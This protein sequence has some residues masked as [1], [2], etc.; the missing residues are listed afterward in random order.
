MPN[1]NKQNELIK[2]YLLLGNSYLERKKYKKALESFN[3]V[4]ELDSNNKEAY[5]NKGY[6]YIALKKYEKALESFNKVIEL[7][8]NNK[9]SYN[10]KGCVKIYLK[11][12]KEALENFNKVIELDPRYVDSYY[13][14]G[15]LYFT[16]FKEYEE[17]LPDFNKVIILKPDYKEAYNSRGILYTKLEKYKEALQDYNKGIELAPDCEVFYFNRGSLYIELKR[18]EKALKDYNKVIEIN[19]N[20]KEAYYNRGYLYIALEKYKEALENFNKAIE[21]NKGYKRAYNSRGILYNILADNEITI[22]EKL[23]YYINA[24]NDFNSAKGENAKINKK[25]TE[26]KLIMNKNDY[27]EKEIKTLKNSKID[28]EK[29]DYNIIFEELSKNKNLA[30]E[31]SYY[32][33]KILINEL[34]EVLKK[35]QNDLNIF[36]NLKKM[37]CFYSAEILGEISNLIDKYPAYR[38]NLIRTIQT[39]F[40]ENLERNYSLFNKKEKNLDI[41]FVF[42]YKKINKRTLEAIIKKG[43]HKSKAEYFNDVFDPFYKKF[44]PKISELLSDIRFSCFSKKCN[45]L[46][47]WA[48]YGDNHRGIC[49]KYKLPK[50]MKKNIFLDE[51]IYSAVKLKKVK[52]TKEDD[53]SYHEIITLEEKGLTIYDAFFRKHKDWQYEEEIRMVYINENEEELYTNIQLEAIYFGIECPNSDINTIKRLCE[54]IGLNIK[55]YK[56]EATEN[57]E[58]KEIL[59]N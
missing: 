33:G 1:N 31:L 16:N 9:E 35:N 48:H 18:Y 55:F 52:I 42:M 41:D 38:E 4:I 43:I 49:L 44:Y 34:K 50:E 23:K 39:D 45:N 22:S 56:M 19:P 54:G 40:L 21:I 32:I 51:I 15:R 30:K 58:L 5:Y 14:R 2:N 59:M 13:N 26:L 8:P 46:L 47:L 17:A 29:I 53:N 10:A 24:I 27:S 6:L 28:I 20:N 37:K 7:D 25:I 36:N 12:Y 3:K 11:K 57:L